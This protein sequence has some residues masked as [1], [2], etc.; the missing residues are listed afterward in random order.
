MPVPVR[1]Q[2]TAPDDADLDALL[3]YESVDV[4]GPWTLIETVEEIGEHPNYLFS[5]ETGNANSRT[6]WFAV[7]WRN[8][9]GIEGDLSA[10]VQGG[11]ETILGEVVQRARQRDPNLSA[12]VL[13]QEAEAAI[14][15]YLGVDPYGNVN[16]ITYRKLNGLVYL[17]MARAMMFDIITRQGGGGY[18]AGMVSERE[19][20]VS[21]SKNAIDSLIALANKSLG[22]STSI[23]LQMED[24]Q[25]AAQ[26]RASYDV[27]REVVDISYQ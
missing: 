7:S 20:D 13:T 5:Y 27:S 18:T 6:D 26:A 24:V 15:Q 21:T 1:L 22:I 4:D 10:P 9:R 11:F 8:V 17:T 12:T 23:I 19:G 25:V 2:F 14:E 3:I 16:T